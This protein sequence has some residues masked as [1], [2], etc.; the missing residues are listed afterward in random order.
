M[1]SW[2]GVD[3]LP[4]LALSYVPTWDRVPREYGGP[5]W[6][7]LTPEGAHKGLGRAILL[8]WPATTD[9]EAR[10]RRAQIY[11]RKSS[12]SFAGRAILAVARPILSAIRWIAGVR[13]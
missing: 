6:V 8:A 7:D 3:D 1:A 13:S 4:R 10:R 11:L 2:D 5:D 9:A 12:P